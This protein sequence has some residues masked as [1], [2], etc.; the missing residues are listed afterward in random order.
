MRKK[1]KAE[2]LETTCNSVKLVHYKY[3]ETKTTQLGKI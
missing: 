2:K 1:K 3:V